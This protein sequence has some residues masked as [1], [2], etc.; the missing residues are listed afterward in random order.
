MMNQVEGIVFRC[1]LAA[2]NR[3]YFQEEVNFAREV[4]K[5]ISQRIFNLIESFSVVY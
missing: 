1:I 2:A 3:D 5:S 4:R